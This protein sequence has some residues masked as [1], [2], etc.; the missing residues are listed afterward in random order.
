MSEQFKI[1][2]GATIGAEEVGRVKLALEELGK[3][4]HAPREITVK[5]TLHVHHDYPRLLYKGN[6][7]RS[8]ANTEEEAVAAKDGFGPYDHKAF[9]AT[10]A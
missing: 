5:A 7:S 1:L 4:P 3:N 2:D 10:E 6:D 9:T 8:V